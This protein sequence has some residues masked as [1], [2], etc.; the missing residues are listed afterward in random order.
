MNRTGQQLLHFRGRGGGSILWGL[1]D[2]GPARS[3]IFHN[4]EIAR[5][6]PWR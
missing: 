1:S 4:R 6:V 3:L 5:G 2:R